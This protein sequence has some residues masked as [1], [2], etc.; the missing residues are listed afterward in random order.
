MCPSTPPKL[1]QGVLE[2]FKRYPETM[3]LQ[4]F[5]SHRTAMAPQWVYDNTFAN[6]TRARTANGGN[7][8]ESAFGGIPFPLPKTG[9]EA[10]WNEQLFWRG[11]SVDDPGSAYIGSSNGRIVLGAIVDGRDEFPYYDP[12]GSVATLGNVYWTKY[13][14]FS[15]PAY[16][17]GNAALTWFELDPVSN[18]SPGWQ[19]L[20]GQRRVRKS[21]NLQYDMPNFF[22]SG[23]GQFDEA[24]GFN[25]ALDRYDWTISGKQEMFIPYNDNKF[26]LLSVEQQMADN[27]HHW[28][29]GAVR[30]ELHRVWAIDAKL[31][32]RRAERRGP[33]ARLPGRGHVERGGG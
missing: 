12:K 26:W 4:V 7:S 16:Q 9:K 30:F 31:A 29:P 25:G 5:P 21:P 6:A 24:F 10:M 15:E 2:L 11:S 18:G 32:P 3:Q 19:Y 17:N 13:Q 20:P 8:L 33:Q 28:S 23:L 14:T 27:R 1:P 22:L